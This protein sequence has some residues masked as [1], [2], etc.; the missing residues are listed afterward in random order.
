MDLP[1]HE[2]LPLS[3]GPLQLMI[4][5]YPAPVDSLTAVHIQATL[6]DHEVRGR[7]ERRKERTRSWE[8]KEGKG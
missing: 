4:A 7:R 5:G 6:N 2:V 3:E 8:G 1:A